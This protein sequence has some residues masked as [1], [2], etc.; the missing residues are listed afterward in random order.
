MKLGLTGNFFSGHNEVMEIFKTLKVKVFDADLLLRYFVN[1]SPTHIKK[2]KTHLGD[3]SYSLGVLNIDRFMDKGQI[4]TILDLCEFDILVSYAR[5]RLMNQ[6]ENYT[7]FKYSYIYER[8]METDFDYMINCHRLQYLREKD[9]KDHT[10]IPSIAINN[11]LRG[12]MSDAEKNI[13]SN[14][15]IRNN[16]SNFLESG[17]NKWSET[18]DQVVKIHNILSKKIPQGISG[19]VY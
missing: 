17:I 10:R 4:E 14:F 7:I 5:F 13:V 6:S 19:E 12:E 8:E 15:V 16:E 3:N 11:L 18:Y 9:L 2:I 1:Y